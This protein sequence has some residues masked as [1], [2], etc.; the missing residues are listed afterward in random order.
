MRTIHH[1]IVPN[2]PS[3]NFRSQ[4][5]WCK[6]VGPLCQNQKTKKHRADGEVNPTSSRCP[7]WRGQPP[8]T[9][10]VPGAAALVINK[11]KV[12]GKPTCRDAH[13][14][15]IALVPTP[16]LPVC[17][18]A[19]CPTASLSMVFLACW[20]MWESISKRT[21]PHHLLEHQGKGKGSRKGQG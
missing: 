18:T 13:E 12:E 6:H 3:Y 20:D 2:P 19:R 21:N 15:E 8:E 1:G 5:C 9:A 14:G 10:V 4:S 17:V 11:Q 16:W 7:D